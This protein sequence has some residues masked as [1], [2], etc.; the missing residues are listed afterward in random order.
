MTIKF[1]KSILTI[2][3]I[4]CVSID[5]VKSQSLID[6]YGNYAGSRGAFLNPSSLTTS[7]VYADFGLNVGVN[8]DNNYFHIPAKDAY[9]AIIAPTHKISY[10][11]II[12]NLPRY[13]DVDFNYGSS[14]PVAA[15]VVV[16]VAMFNG[17]YNF[18]DKQAVAF[19]ARTRA[20]VNLTNIPN[21]LIE[22][23]MV[24]L[25]YTYRASDGY[26]MI[27]TTVQYTQYV[28]RYTPKNINIGVMAWSEIGASYSALVYNR[29]KHRIDMGVNAKIAL[30]VG[31][32]ALSSLQCKYDLRLCEGNE[33][34]VLDSLWFF[35]DLS[36][37]IAYSLPINYDASFSGGDNLFNKPINGFGVGFDIGV[38]YTRLRNPM[39]V[40]GLKSSCFAEPI[41]YI[42]RIGLSVIDIGGVYFGKNNS[43][44]TNYN[45]LSTILDT[46]RF[47]DINSVRQFMNL[48]NETFDAKITKKSFIMGLPTSV[49]L[50]FDCNISSNFFVNA[51]FIQPI[52]IMK[53]RVTSD[54]QLLISP[55]YE[56]HNFDIAV[57]VTYLNYERLLVGA[58]VRIAFFTIG[59]QNLLSLIGRGEVYG[60]D[61]YVSFK[62][63]FRKGRCKI[64][65]CDCLDIYSGCLKKRKR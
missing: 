25:S 17:M 30:A 60:L 46:K 42:W 7:N 56:S 29:Y 22:I 49:S 21:K 19:F 52:P 35:D 40:R 34:K 13:F 54:A 23:G 39:T 27:D 47:N 31:A 14:K 37:S 2:L 36:G 18:K 11:K 48:V 59:T 10:K 53:Y 45:C 58:S 6:I 24:G 55:R 61:L 4:M 41:D 8:A 5:Y 32:A 38:T 63:N 43:E 15:N 44:V 26:T 9:R 12:S 1:L 3:L 28:G 62:Y 64:V 65:D 51:I 16:D 57:P 20:N 33:H 50:Q